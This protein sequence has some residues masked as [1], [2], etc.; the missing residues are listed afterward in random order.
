MIEFFFLYCIDK[1]NFSQKQSD[2]DETYP[3]VGIAGWMVAF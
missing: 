3:M 2:F 1:T